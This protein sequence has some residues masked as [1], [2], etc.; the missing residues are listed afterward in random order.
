MRTALVEGRFEEEGWRMNKDGSRFWASALLIPLREEDGSVRGLVEIVRDVTER[1]R[2]QEALRQ[3]EERFRVLFE[4]LPQ[5]LWV[6][7]VRTPRLLAVNDAA[8]AHY[9]HSR[10]EFLAMTLEDLHP[11]QDVPALRAALRTSLPGPGTVPEAEPGRQR[12]K[13][14]TVDHVECYRCALVFEGRPAGLVLTLDVTEK[15]R[16]QEMFLQAQKMEAVGRLAGGVA[17]DFNNLLTVIN[18]Y[19]QLLLAGLPEDSSARELLK[20]ITRAGDRAASLTGQLLAFSRQQCLTPQA[21][22]L[23]SVI[24]ET[25]KM[26]RRV[27]GE[28]V[29]LAVASDPDLG[30]VKAD[31]GQVVQVLVNLAVNARDAMPA[32][33]KLTIQTRNV[34]LD[35]DHVRDHPAARAGRYVLLEVRD[36]GQG[37][38][39]EVL[40]HIWEPF[41]T[42]KGQGRGTGLG[43]A[44][45][46]GVVKQ[47]GGFAVAR[48]EPGRGTTL[49]LYGPRVDERPVK[50]KSHPEMGVV[51]RG[52]ETVL[53][54]EDEDAVRALVRRVLGGAGY[55]VLD[56]GDGEEAV[57]R[58]GQHSGRIDLVVTDLVLPGCGGREVAERV[59]AMHPG[60]RTLFL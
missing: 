21:L 60:T 51:P 12:K 56:A 30:S 10:D 26:L 42:T 40:P 50:G 15:A 13:D 11:L 28:D 19:G 5:P 14:G 34:S 38:A 33:G 3:S 2:A 36:T 7:D 46:H 52:R 29:E 45:V 49:E 24:T 44:V 57:Q 27:I 18:G 22:D 48:S 16:L 32:G 53:L 4:A 23:R 1:R 9:G 20:E 6:Y 43:L 59:A 54:V 25:E 41:F 17:H 47:A 55:T 31:P 58:A 8:V 39:P 35:A 37:I